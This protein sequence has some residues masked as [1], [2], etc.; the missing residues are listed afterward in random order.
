VLARAAADSTADIR[1]VKALIDLPV[2]RDWRP[3]LAGAAVALALGAIAWIVWRRRRRRPA[4]AVQPID[5]R[6]AHE[7]A[8]DELRSLLAE[9]LPGRRAFREHYSRL[10]G[11]L[12]PYLERRFA[13]HAVERTSREILL[14]LE[15][16]ADSAYSSGRARQLGSLLE[17]ADL[18]KFARLC[19]PVTT[20]VGAVE[21]AMGFVTDTARPAS[22]D[23]ARQRDRQETGP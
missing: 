6:P 14:D 17:E 5:L 15:R 16:V 4:P 7:W 13:I 1:P 10:V 12:R 21:Q 18:V 23:D 8:L 20:A 22:E 3:W 11:I 19:P 9:D 2:P